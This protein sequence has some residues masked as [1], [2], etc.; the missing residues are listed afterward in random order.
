MM[1]VPWPACATAAVGNSAS[2]PAKAAVTARE[3]VSLFMT[4]PFDPYQRVRPDC[5]S[6]YVL[7]Q[8]DCHPAS[9][10]DGRGQ[11]RIARRLHGAR[12]ACRIAMLELL[13]LEF[14]DIGSERRI[15]VAKVAELSRIMLVDFGLD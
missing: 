8:P 1:T 2:P 11:Q 6:S 7:R 3:T 4:R 5:G 14:R 13:G 12:A 10:T 15:V 9:G